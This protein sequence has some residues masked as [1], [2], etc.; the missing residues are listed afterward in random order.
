[1]APKET[2]REL[3][4]NITN[5]HV[6]GEYGRILVGI[7]IIQRV[8]K[9]PLCMPLPVQLFERCT[10]TPCVTHGGCLGLFCQAPVGI[11]SKSG[12]TED[13]DGLCTTIGCL[14]GLTVYKCTLSCVRE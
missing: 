5:Y 3:A 1:M 13:R 8:D 14:Q 11:R 2:Y 7:G 9:V 10:F 4:N 12:Q 6:A